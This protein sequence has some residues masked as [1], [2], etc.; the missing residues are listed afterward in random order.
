MRVEAKRVCVQ[1]E[2]STEGGHTETIFDC[3]FN[4]ADPNI[5]ATASYDS[6]VRSDS[7]PRTNSHRINHGA[8]EGSVTTAGAVEAAVRSS[9]SSY[10]SSAAASASLLLERPMLLFMV[11]V[12]AST[13]DAVPVS[14]LRQVDSHGW[15]WVAGS[16]VGHPQLDVRGQAHG[17]HRSTLLIGVVPG[18]Q[19]HGELKL[20]GQG[21]P[22]RRGQARG[23]AHH[24]EQQGCRLPRR[25]EPARRH[26]PGVRTF[27]PL[28]PGS[29]R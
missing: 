20:R 12:R 17:R 26:A 16:A 2:W 25:V 4:V 9:S 13:V 6:T 18:R 21:V 14:P 10:S 5:L 19:E 24:P 27:T 1:V 29:F 22:L 8:T 11:V 23:G 3:G 15:V 28:R 7:T